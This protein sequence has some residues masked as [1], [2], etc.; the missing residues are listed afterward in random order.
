M[1]NSIS[2][3]LSFKGLDNV[4]LMNNG[5]EWDITISGQ[6]LKKLPEANEIA[7]LF[8]F[9][10]HREDKMKL[11]GFA[12]EAERNLFFDLCSV[13]KIGPSLA[14]KI[15]SG[16]APEEFIKALDAG[17]IITLSHIPGLG[18]KTAEKIIFKL[19]GKILPVGE[20]GSSQDELV[21]AL[22]AMGFDSK[23]AKDALVW[24][25]KQVKTEG[26]NSAQ[27]EQQWLQQSLYF[28]SQKSN[29]S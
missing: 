18:K 19:K 21:K 27:A 1:F 13:E 17:D 16:L 6:T 12:D 20:E 28:L 22:I 25:K 2:G 3:E 4:Y 24:A 7:R 15:L 14:M 9:L 8:I 29:P 26:L 11:Y 10:Y 5:I 23:K